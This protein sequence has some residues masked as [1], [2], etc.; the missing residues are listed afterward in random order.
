MDNA[1]PQLVVPVIFL[2][3][4]LLIY[5]HSTNEFSPECYSGFFFFCLSQL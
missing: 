2:A 1:F 4:G 3:L 5:N